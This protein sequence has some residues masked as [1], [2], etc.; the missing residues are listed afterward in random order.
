MGWDHL[1]RHRS[2]AVGL[3]RVPRR[4]APHE[5]PRA[6][7]PCRATIAMKRYGTNEEV[8]NLTL[9]LASPEASFCTGGVYPVDG[10]FLAA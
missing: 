3:L 4:A 1:G 8:A 9:F 6:S 10:G 2:I 5:G 7:R